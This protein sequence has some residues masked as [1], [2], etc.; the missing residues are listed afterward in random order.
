MDRCN[1]S[2]ESS[3]AREESEEKQSEEKE[4]EEKESEERR[5]RC[6]KDREVAKHCA[7]P[8]FFQCFVAVVR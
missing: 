4:A 6:A 2:D 3:Q 8:I 5:S 7:F 1:N